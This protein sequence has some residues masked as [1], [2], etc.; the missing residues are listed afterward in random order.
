[1]YLKSTQGL[2]TYALKSTLR[3][4]SQINRTL[5]TSHVTRD[6]NYNENFNTTTVN[7]LSRDVND[8]IIIQSFSNFGFRLNNGL[9]AL[10]PIA[11]LPTS[12][13]SW[14]VGS[15][16]DINVQSL[17]LFWLMEPKV[18][19]LVIGT[20]ENREV[21]DPEIRQYLQLRSINTEV[22]DT[23]QACATYNY[24][25][26]ERRNVGVALIPPVR[27]VT[28]S[29]DEGMKSYLVKKR[30]ADMNTKEIEGAREADAL[31]EAF[32]VR[33]FDKFWRGEYGSG[34]LQP[35]GL[36]PEYQANL[37]KWKE[38]KVDEDDKVS[39]DKF[40]PKTERQIIEEKKAHRKETQDKPED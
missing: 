8:I 39:F 19:I 4:I 22:Q 30:F 23:R 26:S 13:F 1:M 40:V 20:G 14:T 16:H 2:L 9:F 18:D 32:H 7:I 28:E 35:P 36:G 12:M 27:L 33:E 3:Q 11:L 15:H 21:I 10:G 29:I 6:A 31:K 24:L 25:A 34:R 37:K 5:F 38:S 17:S